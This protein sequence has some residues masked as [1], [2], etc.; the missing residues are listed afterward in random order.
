MDSEGAARAWAASGA[1]ILT[2]H[3]DGPPL[4]GPLTLPERATAATHAIAELTRGVVRLSWGALVSGRAALLGTRRR[5]RISP[6]G[7]CRL[8][9]AGDGSWVAI[10]LPRR[11]DLE[12]VPALTGLPDN[13]GPWTAVERWVAEE[14]AAAVVERAT[15]L[16]IPA[17]QLHRPVMPQEPV[18]AVPRWT[19]ASPRTAGEVRVVDLSSMWAG[20]L[21]A[22]IL[23]A[24]GAQVAKVE[25]THRPDGARAIPA[26]Y[27]WLHPLDQPSVTFDFADPVSRRRLRSLMQSA[28]VVIEGSR[29]RALEQLGCSPDDMV[30][31][32][33]RVWL[34][35]TGHGRSGPDR[36]RVGFGD[37]AAVAGGLVAWDTDGEPVFCADAI[38]DPLTGLVGARA[39]LDALTSGGGVLLDASLS[40]TAAWVSASD[41]WDSPPLWQAR[42][43][44]EGGWQLD[45]PPAPVPVVEPARPP[46]W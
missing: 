28:D 33:G 45:L 3:A 12:S 11:D 35:I 21:A 14:T 9:R 10:N 24:A 7:S 32:T 41:Q 13:E 40:R 42:S 30:D 38:A 6:G 39:V 17:A 44:T 5:G 23:A 8:L 25:S 27:D 20:P 46:D 19:P 18:L 36:D 15:L 43:T 37:D 34:S 26:F 4:L 16:S 1:M 29:P 2:G 31:R 22:R